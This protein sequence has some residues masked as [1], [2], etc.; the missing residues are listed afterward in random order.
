MNGSR[1]TLKDKVVKVKSGGNCHMALTFNG[2]VY[3]WGLSKYSV[4]MNMKPTQDT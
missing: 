2:H 1:H 4:N 3:V